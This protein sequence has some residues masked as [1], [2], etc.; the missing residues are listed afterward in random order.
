MRHGKEGETLSYSTRFSNPLSQ[1]KY[2]YEFNFNI[3]L[4]YEPGA[5][6]NFQLFSSVG[7]FFSL[8]SSSKRVD[9]PLRGS[10]IFC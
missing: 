4:T 10:Q 3:L 5:Y 7:L 1:V 6:M 9:I 8:I 2:A